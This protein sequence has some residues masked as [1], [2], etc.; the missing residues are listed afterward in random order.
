MK[1]IMQVKENATY[2][3][4]NCFKAYALNVPILFVT[5]LSKKEFYSLLDG[6]YTSEQIQRYEETGS[7]KNSNLCLSKFFRMD[8]EHNE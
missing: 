2:K 1:P 3:Y 7:F 8:G 5:D 4:K 6:K